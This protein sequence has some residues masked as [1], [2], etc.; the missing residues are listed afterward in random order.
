[1][2]CRIQTSVTREEVRT[3]GFPAPKTVA[4]LTNAVPINL[5]SRPVYAYIVTTLK[6][7]PSREIVQYGCAPNFD[8]GRITLCTCKHKDRATFCPSGNR[9]SPWNGVWVAGLTSKTSHPSRSLGYLMLVE[10]TF[11]DHYTLWHHLSP[12]CRNAKS[13]R[14]SRTGDLYEPK[15]AACG[16]PHVPANYHSPVRDHAHAAENNPNQWHNDVREWHSKRDPNGR[17]HPLLLGS[18]QWSYR[19]PIARL[20]LRASGMGA[21]AHHKIFHCL[22]EFL[23]FLDPV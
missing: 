11:P 6:T 21:T 3:A 10:E 20:H 18:E 13:A 8:G 7:T 15:A 17:S 23:A 9:A 2:G 14:R 22:T 1:M 16:M 4:V 19:W 12:T 5:R